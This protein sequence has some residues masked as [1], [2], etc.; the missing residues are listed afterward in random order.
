[1]SRLRKGILGFLALLVVAIVTLGC[2]D[3]QGNLDTDI[4]HVTPQEFLHALD[5]RHYR[6]PPDLLP[7]LTQQTVQLANQLRTN[8]ALSQITPEDIRDATIR[9]AALGV[10]IINSPAGREALANLNPDP[11]IYPLYP[12]LNAM[13]ADPNDPIQSTIDLVYGMLKYPGG[14]PAVIQGLRP[15][16]VA[17]LGEGPLVDTLAPPFN[18]EN[19]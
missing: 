13:V 19:L 10:G 1:M 5:I 6:V 4:R 15:L 3:E 16:L 9:L 12:M 18:E 7:L 8:P 2:A 17:I 11:L 14:L